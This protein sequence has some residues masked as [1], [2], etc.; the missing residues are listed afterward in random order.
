MNYIALAQELLDTVEPKVIHHRALALVEK[1]H[2]D[3]RHEFC[4]QTTDLRV[5]WAYENLIYPRRHE[6]R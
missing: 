6:R 1:K 3:P 5:I 4:L 2:K